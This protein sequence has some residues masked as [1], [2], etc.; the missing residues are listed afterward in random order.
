MKFR[1]PRQMFDSIEFDRQTV[2]RAVA[3]LLPTMVLLY[4]LIIMFV[5]LNFPTGIDFLLGDPNASSYFTVAS[6]ALL[7]V[8]FLFDA[9]ANEREKTLAVAGVVALINAAPRLVYQQ[10]NEGKALLLASILL[11]VSSVILYREN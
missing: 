10:S 7:L 11:F 4:G 9:V 1:S 2:R 8:V 6:Y 3:Y 5:P